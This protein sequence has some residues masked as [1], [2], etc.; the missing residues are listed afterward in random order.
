[1]D[2]GMGGCAPFD[3]RGEIAPANWT[4]S[5]FQRRTKIVQKWRRGVP[6]TLRMSARYGWKQTYVN[7]SPPKMRMAFFCSFSCLLAIG[8]S[9]QNW[10]PLSGVVRC[11]GQNLLPLQLKIWSLSAENYVLWLPT[12]KV[13]QDRMKCIPNRSATMSMYRRK[14]WGLT[15]GNLFN[16][17]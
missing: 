1:M 3:R 16:I 4:T 5:K 7:Q 10:K 6:S 14:Y 11:K 9:V 15:V 2:G 13:C 12:G 17:H 8:L